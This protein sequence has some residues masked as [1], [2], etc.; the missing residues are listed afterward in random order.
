[1]FFNVLIATCENQSVSSSQFA[2]PVHEPLIVP[3]LSLRL[4]LPPPTKVGTIN[5]RATSLTI[6]WQPPRKWPEEIGQYIVR[7]FTNGIAPQVKTIAG[8]QERIARFSGL[9]K[10]TRYECTVQACLPKGDC[11]AHS[12]M[13]YV[14]TTDP[15]NLFFCKY[16]YYLIS[17]IGGGNQSICYLLVDACLISLVIS[18]F[19]SLIGS[20]LASKIVKFKFVFVIQAT[21]YL[22]WKSQTLVIGGRFSYLPSISIIW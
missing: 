21:F 19:A 22:N 14:K 3:S 6:I 20:H 12:D 11:S 5:V 2:H 13:L 17:A 16:L 1:M 4:D 8:D 9:L 18:R 15:G 7:A 10:N